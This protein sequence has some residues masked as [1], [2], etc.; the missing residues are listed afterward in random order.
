MGAPKS[1]TSAINNL[2]FISP[3]FRFPLSTLFMSYRCFLPNLAEFIHKE[4]LKGQKVNVKIKELSTAKALPSGFAPGVKRISGN[5]APL[6]P[7]ASPRYIYTCSCFY[8]L[9]MHKSGLFAEKSAKIR[10]KTAHIHN[11]KFPKK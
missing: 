9:C 7:R 2:V 11:R 1:G 6:F 8:L 3:H 4:S 5:R 10:L